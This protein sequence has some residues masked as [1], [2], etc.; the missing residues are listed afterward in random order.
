MQTVWYSGGDE[1]CCRSDVCVVSRDE[2]EVEVTGVLRIHFPTLLPPAIFAITLDVPSTPHALP[3]LIKVC[4]RAYFPL[5]HRNKRC[6][7]NL[8]RKQCQ[9]SK[10]RN[11]NIRDINTVSKHLCAPQNTGGGIILLPPD[12]RVS[13]HARIIHGECIDAAESKPTHLLIN[14]L[15]GT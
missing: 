7:G 11:I 10:E 15:D 4:L 2:M 6:G 14:S 8:M 3:A 5:Y 1:H 12:S 9:W 13:E